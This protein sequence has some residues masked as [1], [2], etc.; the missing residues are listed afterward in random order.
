M[1]YKT[2]YYI[3]QKENKSMNLLKRAQIRSMQVDEIERKSFVNQSNLNVHPI[4]TYPSVSHNE[5]IATNT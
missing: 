1:V 4:S 5:T 2:K 3:Y